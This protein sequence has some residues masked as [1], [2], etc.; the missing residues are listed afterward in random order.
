[1][2]GGRYRLLSELGRGGMGVVYRARDERLGRLVAIKT[3]SETLRSNAEARDLFIEEGRQLA[4]LSHPNL[5]AIFDVTT[6]GEQDVLISE[7]VEGQNL[8]ELLA[9]EP[10]D[11]ITALSVA[12]QMT[13]GIAYLHDQGV[14]HRD[15]KPAN[16]MLK[17]DGAI[18]LIDFGLARSL[19]Q[20][21]QKGTQARGTP[22][23]MAPEQLLGPG[24][25]EATDVYQLAVTFYMILTREFPF[26]LNEKAPWAHI[27]EN[28]I[29][30]LEE[31]IAG[32]PAKLCE[33]IRACLVKDPQARP[34]TRALL[35]S[36]IDVYEQLPDAAPLA[37][38]G[39]SSGPL[40]ALRAE[41]H[42]SRPA[43]IGSQLVV[44]QT[45][46]P[47]AGL[48]VAAAPKSLILVLGA[49]VVAIVAAVALVAYI[50]WSPD[51][52]S[53]GL[54]EQFEA[55][56]VP[57]E[58]VAAEVVAAEVVAA[59]EALVE[60]AEPVEPVEQSGEAVPDVGV[61]LENA[62]AQP[63]AR[64]LSER[65]KSRAERPQA[66]GPVE[67]PAEK[68]AEKPIEPT[69][70][71]DVAPVAEKPVERL[72]VEPKPE[73]AVVSTKKVVVEEPKEEPVKKAPTVE[74]KPEK[75]TEPAIP[76]F[77]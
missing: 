33:T 51:A 73:T 25:S 46:S 8:D 44:A 31:R 1:M 20:V 52:E 22:A 3:L 49:I 12:I 77:F 60:V 18:K 10:L 19:D 4:T 14:I 15:I 74:P 29:I 66:A 61:A 9:R 50:A 7:L 75:K 36:L 71:A 11:L 58:V 24:P 6:E 23:Y 43:L 28:K 13:E 42:R 65:A 55:A 21:M 45:L 38:M 47:Q 39:N 53:P 41:R 67:K 5:V 54:A 56:A 48:E 35:A 40:A 68:P 69:H 2:I 26:E 72:A 64:P 34:S 17:P 27:Y 59:E 57:A 37:M 70:V 30:G 62:S 63:V 32:L 16:A 76:R